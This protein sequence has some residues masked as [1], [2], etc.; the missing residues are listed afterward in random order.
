MKHLAM[1]ALLASG[2]TLSACATDPYGYNNNNQQTNRALGGAAIGGV[3]GAVAGAVLP[4]VN[5]VT[6]AVAGAVLGGV[7]GAVVGTLLS[8]LR[9]VDRK[10][11]PF[12][13]FMLIGAWLGVLLGPWV[14][15]V[16]LGA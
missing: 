4:G 15:G 1:T 13:P 6:G 11:Y 2:L 12:G 10:A 9:L 5:P 16:Y 3:A 14:A 8:L 7:L